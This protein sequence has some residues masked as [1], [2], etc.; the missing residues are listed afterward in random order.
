MLISE[1]ELRGLIG[2]HELGR[3]WSRHI[4][5][6]TAIVDFIPDGS[7][8][9]DVGT[10]AGFPGMVIA[11]IRPDLNLFLVESME[12][13]SAWLHDVVDAIGLDNVEIYH[14]RA[15]RLSHVIQA[16]IVTARAVASVRR[17]LPLTMPL[18]KSS[19]SLLTLKGSRVDEEINAAF[20]VFRKTR[21]AWADVYDVIPFGTNEMTRV[22]EVRKK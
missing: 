1:G 8:V 7:F 10:G 12:R 3:L 20:D 14:G 9:V 13:R 21:A 19:G 15:E 2:P 18:L 16:D 17:L 6:S 22:L 11:I 4:L 5:N